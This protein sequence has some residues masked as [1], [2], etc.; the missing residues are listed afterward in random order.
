MALDIEKGQFQT[1]RRHQQLT[2]VY[3]ACQALDQ[4]LDL[5]YA[6]AT[7]PVS[8]QTISQ[9]TCA[10]MCRLWIPQTSTIVGLLGVG[11]SKSNYEELS[12][13]VAQEMQVVATENMQQTFQI[14]ERR[15][16]QTVDQFPED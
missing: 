15:F 3:S 2:L 8:R 5:T 13:W 4:L 10:L 6:E 1:G 12:K 11:L 16:R 14:L 9:I 7:D